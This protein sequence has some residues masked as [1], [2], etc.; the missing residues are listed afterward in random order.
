MAHPKLSQM[1]SK[2]VFGLMVG[3]RNGCSAGIGWLLQPALSEEEFGC[4]GQQHV[5]ASMLVT[6]PCMGLYL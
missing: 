2:P 3:L 1:L 6:T 5:T 4:G